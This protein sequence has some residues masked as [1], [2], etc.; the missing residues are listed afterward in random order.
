MH[1]QYVT[2]L[3]NKFL[4]SKFSYLLFRNSTDKTKIGIANGWAT[5][6]SKPRGSNQSLWLANQDRTSSQIIFSTLFSDRCIAVLRLLSASKHA[7][8]KCWAKANFTEPN[9]NQHVLTFLHPILMCRITYW[10]L[11]VMVWVPKRIWEWMRQKICHLFVDPSSLTPFVASPFVSG[12]GLGSARL[13]SY[14]WVIAKMH[15]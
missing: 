12:N 4:T 6:N 7:L 11:L 5:T 10:A 13:F 8:L 15:M 14:R 3:K 9:P 1:I 2:L